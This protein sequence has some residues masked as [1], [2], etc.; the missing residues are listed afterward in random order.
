[1]FADIACETETL[2]HWPPYLNRGS[3]IGF[4]NP[5]I[6]TKIFPAFRNP[7]RFYRPIPIPVMTS[8]HDVQNL[9]VNNNC[10]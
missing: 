2:F 4:F 8:Q 6:P 1:M 3:P 7:E 10:T 5:A 9:V